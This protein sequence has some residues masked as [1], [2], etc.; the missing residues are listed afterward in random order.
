[1]IQSNIKQL[2]KEHGFTIVEL[3]VVIVVIGIL[4]AITV[5]SYVG[6]TAKANATKAL[7]NASSVQSVV[8]AYNA[9]PP[10]GVF[11]YPTFATINNGNIKIPTGITVALSAA[12]A[13]TS[14]NGLTTVSYFNKG[15]TGGCIGYW[16]YN[17]SGIKYVY[18]GD[19]TTGGVG[20]CS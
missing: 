3:L 14:G 5:V 20:T 19:A 4:A 15:T 6:I 16:D 9:D 1:M 11:G 2:K 18:A 12:S 10:T 8:E 13:V 17:T 7:A